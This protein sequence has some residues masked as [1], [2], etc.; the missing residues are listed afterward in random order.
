MKKVMWLF[1]PPKEATDEVLRPLGLKLAAVGLLIL[2]LG[3]A[4]IAFA[5]RSPHAGAEALAEAERFK[6]QGNG[7]Q[8]SLAQILMFAFIAPAGFGYLM[9]VGGLHKAILGAPS[10]DGFF[11]KLGRGLVGFILFMIT[12]VGSLIVMGQFTG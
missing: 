12:F 8:M 1:S 7:S 5:S 3:V 6:V 4:L 2:V 10:S 9:L 11:V